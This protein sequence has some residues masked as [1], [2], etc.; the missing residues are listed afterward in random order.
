MAGDRISR[1][2]RAA[3]PPTEAGETPEAPETR[4]APD[5]V[6]TGEA[7]PAPGAPAADVRVSDLQALPVQQL[8]ELARREGVKE[9]TS[10]KKQ[11]LIFRIL[12][13]RVRTDG[14]ATAEG[15][16]EVLPDGYGFLRSPRYNYLPSPDDVYVSQALARRFGLQTGL[17][18]RGPIRPPKEGE[19]TFSLTRVDAVN[20]RDP[21]L[22]ETRVTFEDL[23]PIYPKKRLVLET[24][25]D[26]ASMRVVDLVAPIGKGQRGLI[27]A[28]PRT[29]KTMLLQKIGNAVLKNNPEA[30]LIVLLVDERP[31]EVTDFERSVRGKRVEVVSSTFDEPAARHIQVAEMV[32][33]RAKRMVEYGEDVVI[34]LDSI[35]R[36]GRAY[37]SEAPH[38]GKIMTGGIDASALK[39]PKRFFGAARNIE[40]GGSLT[41]VATALVETGSRM[42]EVIFEEFKGTGNMELHLDRK[43]A[44][45]RTWPAIDAQK[46]GT[47]K[48]ELLCHPDE[49]KRMWIIRRVLAEMNPVE[50]MELLVEK[51]KKTRTN[52]E[53]L[54]TVSEAMRR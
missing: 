54:L 4:E 40:E 52:A 22:V 11:E 5:L 30:F 16:L 35:T 7:G 1:T 24:T 53:L 44:D 36:L 45:R 18:V 49:L 21:G 43:L 33:E 47:R 13:N 51:V 29:G 46:S 14:V 20:D 19:R 9:L 48:E 37:N 41:I 26:E 23:T 8:L 39:G 10:T 15:V 2:E 25:P 3:R 27:V 12:S 38:S 34:L 28:S 31:E 17:S 6:D 42:D 50:A 32:V